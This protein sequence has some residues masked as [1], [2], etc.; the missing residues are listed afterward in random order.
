VQAFVFRFTPKFL[1]DN[2]KI[3]HL[4]QANQYLSI[5][6]AANT[7]VKILLVQIKRTSFTSADLSVVLDLRAMQ[8]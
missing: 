2:V 4:V 3:G 5:R 7:C 6:A 1:P 8:H